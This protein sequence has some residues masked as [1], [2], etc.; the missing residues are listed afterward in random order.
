MGESLRIDRL[1]WDEWNL[2]HIR[3]HGLGQDDVE[4][5]IEHTPIAQPT[6]KGHWL[7]LGPN[8][9]NRII[10]VVIG[11]VPDKP[12]SFYPF[13]ARPASRKERESYA[14]GS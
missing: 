7:L 4:Y 1:E 8:A 3:K 9:D 2:D 5:L 6:H 14:L 12:N 10:A 13:S 11:E